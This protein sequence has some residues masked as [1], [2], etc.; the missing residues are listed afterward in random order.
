MYSMATIINSPG[1]PPANDDGS[2]GW[3][4][5]IIILIAV[6]GIGAYLL[7]Y[8]RG[9]PTPAANG[10]TNVNVTLPAQQGGTTNTPGTGG[11]GGTGTTP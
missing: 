10:G 3:S 6:I 11:T 1:N 5:A 8:Y 4:V 2:A 7:F 9:A